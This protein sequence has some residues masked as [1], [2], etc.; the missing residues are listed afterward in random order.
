MAILGKLFGKEGERYADVRKALFGDVP[1]DLWPS[2]GSSQEFPWTAFIAAR[3]HLASGNLPAAVGCWREILDRPGLNPRHYLQAWRFL[4]KFGGENPPPAVSK[5][6]LGFVVEVGLP[7]G[8]DSLAAYADHSARYYNFSG[9]CFVWEH[10]DAS[11]DSRIDELLAGSRPAL[12]GATIGTDSQQKP[13]PLGHARLS[14]LTP[15]GIRVRQDALTALAVDPVA[16][17]VLLSAA[18]LMRELITKSG[19]GA[20]T[21]FPAGSADRR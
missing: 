6:L 16:G 1:P 15:G 14:W 7:Q 3:A 18:G 8:I 11:L 9:D 19:T 12:E 4:G 21:P 10:R 13:P 2:E 17:P 20:G 5:H